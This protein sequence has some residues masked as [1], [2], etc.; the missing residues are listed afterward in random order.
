M[1]KENHF[2]ICDFIFETRTYFR[3]KVLYVVRD[4]SENR[5]TLHRLSLIP[6]FPC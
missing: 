3:D 1:V 5:F 6:G 2:T 4:K